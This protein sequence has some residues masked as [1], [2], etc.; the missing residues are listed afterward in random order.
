MTRVSEKKVKQHVFETMSEQL[1]ESVLHARTK[2]DAKALLREL[3]TD[4][5]RV[6]LAKRF[7]IIVMLVH[8][9]S[10]QQ[11]QTL[12]SVSPDTVS[13][14]WREIKKGNYEN[15]ARYAKNNP[16]KIE[17]GTLLRFIVELAE[18]GMPPRGRGRWAYFNKTVRRGKYYD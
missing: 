12:L 1:I 13:R 10:F 8:R 4:T 9:Y 2:R 14:L 18:V 6:M 15:L 7:A 3:L 5:E 17:Q 16:K 11:I